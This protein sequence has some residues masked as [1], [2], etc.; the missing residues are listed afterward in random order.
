MND[1]EM[2]EEAFIDFLRTK[3]IPYNITEY[4]ENNRDL[5]EFYKDVTFTIRIMV[6]ND[7]ITSPQIANAYLRIATKKTG[8]TDN[9]GSGGVCARINLETGEIFEPE[10][11]RNHI[12]TPCPV[13]PDTGAIIRGVIPNWREIKE[14]VKD[15]SRYICQLEYM[16]FDVVATEDSFKI[17]EINTHQDLH[18][19]HHY[20]SEVHRY[21]MEKVDERLS[22]RGR[23]NHDFQK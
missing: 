22:K 15:V 20:G 4:L 6:I 5:S 2:E 1:E 10:K 9:I 23:D 14:G 11:L 8:N 12:I 21:F 16:G 13:H 3:K 17:L 19:Y 18:R 7:K